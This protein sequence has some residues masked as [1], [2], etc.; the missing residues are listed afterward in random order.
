M[1]EYEEELKLASKLVNEAIKISEWFRSSGFTSFEKSDKTPVTLADMATQIFIV[2]NIKEVF[3][4]DQII[5]EEDSSFI[6]KE[7]KGMIMKCFKELRFSS[8]KNIKEILNY[9]GSKST[10]QW[11]IDPIDGTKGFQEGLS[12]AIGISFRA[13]SDTKICAISVPNYDG[14]T[15]G[16]FTATKGEGARASHEGSTFK[17]IKVS[18]QSSLKNASLL[19][20]L[21][22]DKPWVEKFAE[23]A[24]IEHKTRADSMLKFCKIAEGS[25]DL[26]LKPI[27]KEHSHSWDYAPGDLLVREAGGEVTDLKGNSISF[28][29]E[30]CIS[31]THGLVV[32]NGLLHDDVLKILKENDLIKEKYE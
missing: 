12:Y 9:K 5:A 19:H 1:S 4:E 11:T 20:S 18:S 23:I 17:P 26:Y 25:A 14:K 30:R 31:E 32:S 27:D 28:K 2:S 8:L 16:L 15:T 6:D 3:P 24:N 21:H 10:R 29:D 22:Y 7:T 13:N